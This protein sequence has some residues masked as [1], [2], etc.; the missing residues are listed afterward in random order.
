M[1]DANIVKLAK[2]LVNYSAGVKKDQLVR[3]SGPTLSLP[4]L[5][6]VYREAI[7]VGAH[8][9]VR[10]APEELNE[11]MLKSGS[12]EQLRFLNP[13][14]QFEIDKIDC[15]ISA[16]AESNT[17]ALTNC[18]PKKNGTHQCRPKADH[19]DLLETGRRGDRSSGPGRNS[20]PRLP[21]R[22]RR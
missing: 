17:R 6:E 9:F 2:V 20:P 22:M 13:I 11:I 10:V 7:A 8:P 18:D 14:A 12:D 5:T 19:G 21:L 4:L 3:I 16:W 1:A 15:T